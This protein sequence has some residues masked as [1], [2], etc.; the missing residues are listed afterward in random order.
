MFWHEL[1]EESGL[2]GCYRATIPLE[3]LTDDSSRLFRKLKP[4]GESKARKLI[5]RIWNIEQV[6][7]MREVRPMLMP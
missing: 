5:D 7:N 1:T 2:R 3:N 4:L 6:A